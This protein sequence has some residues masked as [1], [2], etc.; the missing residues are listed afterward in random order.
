[1]SEQKNIKNKRQLGAYYEQRAASYLKQ[2]GY[3][4]IETNF[5]CKLGE[6]DIIAIDHNYTVFVEV[7]YRRTIHYGYPREAVHYAKQRKIRQV[8]QYFELIHPEQVKKYR[9]DIIEFLG[10]H[11]THLQAVF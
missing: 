8:A 5:R 1:M 7:K 11:L 6:I 4:V 3:Q 10:D 9:F 2:I